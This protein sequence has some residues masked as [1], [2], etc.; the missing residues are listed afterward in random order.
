MKKIGVNGWIMAG[1]WILVSAVGGYYTFHHQPQQLDHLE[2]AEQVADMKHAELVMLETE[3]ASL[4]QMADDAVRKWRARYKVIPEKQTTADVVGY[5]NGL[6][7]RGFKNF[8]VTYAGEHR[9][10][11][12]AFY[13]FQVSGR[14]Y[15]NSLYRL[16]WELENNRHFYRVRD[17][18]LDHIDLVTQDKERGTDRLEVMVSFRATV[19]AY[20]DGID[21]ASAPKELDAGSYEDATITVR[22]HEDLPPVPIDVLPDISPASNPFYPAVLADIPPNTY[23]YIDVENAKLLSVAGDKAVFEDDEGIRSARVGEEVYLGQIVEI[24]PV[25]GYVMARLNKGGIIDE[26]VKQLDVDEPYRQAM[27]SSRLSPV[28]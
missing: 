1:C 9:S 24:D 20:F 11:D 22:G 7:D 18:S 14:A 8:D 5:F 16:I 17:L 27:G 19:N 10:E 26:V 13:A 15:Y 25:A 2:K 3:Q 21:G 12:Y 4:A 23:G 28:N 6:T